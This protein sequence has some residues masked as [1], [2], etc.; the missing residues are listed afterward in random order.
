MILEYVKFF[1]DW[2]KLIELM[3]LVI[4]VILQK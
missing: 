4:F 3:K 2:I 1:F